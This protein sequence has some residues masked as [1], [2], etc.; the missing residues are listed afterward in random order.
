MCWGKILKYIMLLCLWMCVPFS[1]VAKD[2]TFAA[3]PWGI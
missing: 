2:V 1:A 3:L